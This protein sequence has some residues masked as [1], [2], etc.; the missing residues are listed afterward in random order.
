ML[1]LIG[2]TVGIASLSLCG[3]ILWERSAPTSVPAPVP[4]AAR[5]PLAPVSAAIR[6][7]GEPFPSQSAR[8]VT[9]PDTAALKSSVGALLADP[10]RSGEAVR[11]ELLRWTPDEQ[12]LPEQREEAL[13]HFLNLA[14]EEPGKL[15]VPLAVAPTLTALLAEHAFSALLNQAHA[16][17]ANFCLGLL[18]RTD[19]VAQATAWAHLQFFANTTY[20]PQRPP[21]IGGA[22]CGLRACF[23]KR[24]PRRVNSP[25]RS[26]LIPTP[27]SYGYLVA[28]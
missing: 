24:L 15:I 13:T 21:Q 16:E 7:F 25:D 23:H 14:A 9:V 12:R 22:R 27:L 20:H 8:Q 6:G 26:S 28:Y 4:A 3:W 2:A 19:G 1:G 17:Q 11:A 18:T 5:E 10:R